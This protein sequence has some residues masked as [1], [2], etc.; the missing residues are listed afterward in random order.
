MT[1]T[2][3]III[4]AGVV[5]IAFGVLCLI[6]I[7]RSQRETQNFAKRMVAVEKDLG[8]I[9]SMVSRSVQDSQR[10]D[11]TIMRQLQQQAAKQAEMETL[12]Q[13]DVQA[14]QEALEALQKETVQPVPIQPQAVPV[15][16][17]QPQE[18]PKEPEPAP[19]DTVQQEVQVEESIQD[20]NMDEIDINDLLDD[21]ED[22]L[23]EIYDEPVTM[24]E[25]GSVGM[26]AFAPAAEPVLKPAV[27]PPT[28][29]VVEPLAVP[30]VEPE[31]ETNVPQIQHFDYDIGKSGKTYT[32][33]ELESLI[34]E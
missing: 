7:F 34:R 4:V 13:A 24:S 1:E 33:D 12:R 27:E 9:G 8:D 31:P 32:A 16:E 30:V 15:P 17:Q 3:M 25:V 28:A 14:T 21:F 10:A 11:E 22:V 6:T 19:R 2:M 29:P 23:P 18:M 20:F 26:T 5:I